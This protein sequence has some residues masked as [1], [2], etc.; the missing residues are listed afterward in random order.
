MSRVLIVDDEPLARDRL[1]RLIEQTEGY[2]VCADAENGE[3][4]LVKTADF[5]P[6]I[7]LMDIRMPTM[8]GLEAARQITRADDSPA[9][10]FCTAYDDYA[11]EAFQV[12]AIGYLM[13][14]VRLEHLQQALS[15]SARLNRLQRKTV[16]GLAENGSRPEYFVAHTYKGSQLIEIQSIQYFIA[17]QKYVTVHHNRGETLVDS[18]LKEIEAQFPERLLRIHRST[19]VNVG[20]VEALHREP[21]GVWHV[22]LKD[23][24]E[25]LQ[26]S[27]RHVQAVKNWIEKKK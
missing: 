23:E 18:T 13:K 27:R 12:Q 25:K 5:L 10:I 11:I 17:D 22:V 26:V 21:D 20:Y 2:E 9:I 4:A 16:D 8:D 6:D 7:I 1:R 14:P 3:Q 24:S 19:L 15:Q